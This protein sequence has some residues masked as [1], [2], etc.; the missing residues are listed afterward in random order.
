MPY[1]AV[2]SYT[3]DP[4]KCKEHET[5]CNTPRKGG[6]LC[7]HRIF[8]CS[9]AMKEMQLV[10][11][12]IIIKLHVSDLCEHYINLLSE[13]LYS[14][15]SLKYSILI[16]KYV[17]LWNKEFNCQT[18][19]FSFLLHWFVNPQPCHNLMDLKRERINEELH[20]GWSS[21]NKIYYLCQIFHSK[22]RHISTQQS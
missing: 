19:F 7:S 21:H 20:R 15:F 18:I 5:F 11:N 6:P 16:L 22:C 12:W 17:W 14:I 13:Q 10:S 4:A 9:A 2:R 3:K 8:R 1:T